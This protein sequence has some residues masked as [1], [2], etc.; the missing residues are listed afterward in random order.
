VLAAKV[1]VGLLVGLAAAAY[2]LAVAFIALG[3]AEGIGRDV[4]NPDGL[5]PLVGFVPFV[6]LNM[7]MGM[8][9]GAV[10][11]NTAAAVALQFV[12]P[13]VWGMIAL[14]ALD[15]VGEWLDPGQAFDWLLNGTV[16]EHGWQFVTSISLWILLPLAAGLLR[17][18]RREVS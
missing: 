10:L 3:I 18:A 16:A 14:G 6:L 4:T 2:A 17:T 8:A 12:L 13:T 11:H 7:L 1:V 5:G 9:F 15:T